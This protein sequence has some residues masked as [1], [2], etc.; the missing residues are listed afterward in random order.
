MNW[1][2]IAKLVAGAL[3]ALG[4]TAAMVAVVGALGFSSGGIVAGSATAGIMS[5]YGGSVAAGSFCAIAQSIGAIGFPT[6]VYLS[7]CIAGTMAVLF[8][9]DASSSRL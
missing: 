9:G 7:P 3:L 4:V 6:S 8:Q 1:R 2:K 5:S